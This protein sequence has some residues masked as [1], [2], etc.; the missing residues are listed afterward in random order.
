MSEPKPPS[1]FLQ[2][3][4]ELAG[5][6]AQE[7]I[8]QFGKTG[9][10]LSSD[11]LIAEAKAESERAME[12]LVSARF[13]EHG[14][15]SEKPAM[16]DGAPNLAEFTW[17]L[18]PI[19][20]A[21]SFNLGLPTFSSLVAL[22]RNGMP[23]LGVVNIPALKETLYAELGYGCWYLNRM[24][25]L[26]KAQ[27]K[28]ETQSLSEAIVSTSD[29]SGT[30]INPSPQPNSF[31]LSSLIQKAHTFHFIG[32]SIKHTLV[33]RGMIDAAFDAEMNPWKSAA[34]IP[35]ILEAGGMISGGGGDTSNLVNAGS[36][37]S[38]SSYSLHRDIL[39][40]IQVD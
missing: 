17:V 18:N 20:G 9:T 4:L 13:P 10:S 38:S 35:C 15:L 7:L 29:V 36:M 19:D 31:D 27:V 6:V 14:I 16:A 8:P 26:S 3:A 30:D 32:D 5:T 12:E 24:G 23:L 25:E 22:L 37:V 39:E 11:S 28:S 40:T 33:A 2:F 34:I 1:P 21:A